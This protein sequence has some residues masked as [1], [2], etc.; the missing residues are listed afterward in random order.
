M[1]EITVRRTPTW[2]P[3]TWELWYR[4]ISLLDEI[5]R[6]A[7]TAWDTW[8]P[9]T[10]TPGTDMY[11]Y[12]DELVL[13]MEFPGIRREDIDISLEGD[14]L[15]V[16]AEKNQEEYPEGTKWYRHERWYGTYTR[17]WT[18][19]YPVDAEKVSAKLEYGVLEIR[20]PKAEVAKAKKIEVAVK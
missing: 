1:A 19:P 5:E 12:K 6:W 16:K 9:E 7:G 17:T 14:C 3:A 18:L 20:L 13:R 4:P 10:Y 11:E 15:T 2:T 8:K